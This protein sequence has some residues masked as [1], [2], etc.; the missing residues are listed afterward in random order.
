MPELIGTYEGEPT[1]R[2]VPPSHALKKK[3]A[4]WAFPNVQLLTIC[5]Y[6]Q[7]LGR[8]ETIAPP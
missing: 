5:Q 4:L 2:A 3:E 7:G 8:S 6:F 1:P